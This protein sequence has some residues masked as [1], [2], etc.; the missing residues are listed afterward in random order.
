[1]AEYNGGEKERNGGRKYSGFDGPTI[2]TVLPRGT[3]I[4]HNPDGT[5]T[6]I[7]PENND[8]KSGG[9]SEKELTERLLIFL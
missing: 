8:E 2:G 9:M 3:T 7:Q 4:K 6:L 5:I 1:M